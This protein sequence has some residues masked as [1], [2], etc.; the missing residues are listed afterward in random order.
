MPSRSRPARTTVHTRIQKVKLS[1]NRKTVQPPRKAP[2]LNVGI[3]ATAS[4]KAGEER[5]RIMGEWRSG[6]SEF[7][8]LGDDN[9][10]ISSYVHSQAR[11]SL[12]PAREN[13]IGSDGGNW[14]LS[15]DEAIRAIENHTS[16]FYTLVNSREAEVISRD[17]HNG[18]KYIK[19][20]ADGHRPDNLLSLSECGS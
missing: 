3:E 1:E 19:T 13:R 11:F 7:R 18:G 16:F 9:G 12:W 15:E 8:C 20:T 6:F 10:A 14:T 4:A 5:A 2:R 17:T